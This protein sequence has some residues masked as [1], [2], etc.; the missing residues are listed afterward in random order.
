MD[1]EKQLKRAQDLLQERRE[2]FKAAGRASDY[3]R[4]EERRLENEVARQEYI[5]D[6]GAE[7]RYTR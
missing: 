3:D 5:R 1:P 7:G 2:A 4:M 6:F